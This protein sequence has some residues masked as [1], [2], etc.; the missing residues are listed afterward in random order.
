MAV[1]G[2][3]ISERDDYDGLFEIGREAVREGAHVVDLCVAFTGRDE[4]K[5][6]AE[7]VSRFNQHV[8]APLMIDSTEPQ[9]LEEALKRISGKPIINSINL[10][11]EK[12]VWRRSVYSRKYGAAVVAP[13]DR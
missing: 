1:V 13:C 5:D 11:M 3:Q 6:M 8:T 12:T 9:V 4:K 10:R 2:L 7:A